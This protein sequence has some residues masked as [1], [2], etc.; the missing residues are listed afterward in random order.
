MTT[1]LFL[2]D[3]DGCLSEPFLPYNLDAL[4][5]VRAAIHAPGALPFALLTGRAFPYAEAMSQVL[6]LTA[7]AYFEAGSGAFL[8]PERRVVWHPAVTDEVE[9]ALADVRAWMRGTLV[10]AMPSL[11][12]DYGKRV[13]AGV[14]GATPEVVAEAAARVR[15]RIAGVGAPLV[16]FTTPVSVD[17]VPA[18]L[19][20]GTAL[21]WIADV[22][23]VAVE[24]MAF[25][26]D[27]EGDREALGR[28]GRA[29]APANAAP[30]IRALPH[31]TV[32]AEAHTDGV[33]QAYTACHGRTGHP[34]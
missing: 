28:V 11:V 17:V 26:G 22:T 10:A 16:V 27:T 19:T 34:S 12:F 1:D 18:G 4:A 32:T 6:G 24:R 25:I 5:R 31:V 13:Q 14:L 33:L 30:E 29:F 23:G 7:P 20:K 2:S 21:D 3:V 9:A 15:E 8:R